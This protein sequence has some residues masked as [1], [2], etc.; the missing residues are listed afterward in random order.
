[1]ELLTRGENKV[2]KKSLKENKDSQVL[3]KLKC[4]QNQ[5]NSSIEIE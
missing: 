3:N 2:Y 4:L 1:M 5:L